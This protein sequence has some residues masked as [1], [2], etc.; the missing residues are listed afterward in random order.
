MDS[1]GCLVPPRA[2]PYD[3]ATPVTQPL[4]PNPCSVP[5]LWLP[6]TALCTPAKHTPLRQ[7]AGAVKVCRA[8]AHPSHFHSIQGRR[9]PDT[10]QSEVAAA[11]SRVSVPTRTSCQL[12]PWAPVS[13]RGLK[14]LLL[15]DIPLA[16]QS[17]PWQ[18]SAVAYSSACRGNMGT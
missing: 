4:P 17:L 12:E 15:M 7:A 16:W 1:G 14:C 18:G 9:E 6:R 5:D 2:Y 13:T 11:N 8:R 3:L 10:H